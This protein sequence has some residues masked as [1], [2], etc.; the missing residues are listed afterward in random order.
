MTSSTLDSGVLFI[1]RFNILQGKSDLVNVSIKCVAVN[2]FTHE[3]FK[4]IKFLKQFFDFNLIVILV[5][6]F[7]QFFNL[8]VHFWGSILDFKN[9]GLHLVDVPGMGGVLASDDSYIVSECLHF[10]LEVWEFSHQPSLHSLKRSLPSKFGKTFLPKGFNKNL[11]FIHNS[12][13]FKSWRHI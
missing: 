7:W 5:N 4:V 6:F 11:N 2:F 9:L 10:P 13:N 1:D 12:I 3:F 8:R